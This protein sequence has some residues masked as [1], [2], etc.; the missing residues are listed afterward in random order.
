MITQFSSFVNNVCLFFSKKIRR[1]VIFSKVLQRL[2]IY[3]ILYLKKYC[4]EVS[5][6]W[7]ILLIVLGVILLILIAGIAYFVNFGIVRNDKRC[8]F[9][10]DRAHAEKYVE[11]EYLETVISGSE[12]IRDVKAEDLYMTSFDGLHLHARLAV[13]SLSNSHSRVHR[14]GTAAPRRSLP[15]HPP[16]I[17]LIRP[18]YP[19]RSL[20]F[21][22]FFSL[23]GLKTTGWG[24]Y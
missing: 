24:V 23:S 21:F 16:H 19:P 7:I 18:Q 6:W 2:Y 15:P 12:W 5:M 11:P 17:Q 10:Y 22:A 8:G 13:H 3:D 14:G 1:C 4:L 9:Y 20:P